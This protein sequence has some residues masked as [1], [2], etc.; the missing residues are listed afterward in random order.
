MDVVKRNN[1]QLFEGRLGLERMRDDEAE[2]ETSHR[3]LGIEDGCLLLREI[4]SKQKGGGPLYR[5]P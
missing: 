4:S 1:G 2:K 5:N 3:P